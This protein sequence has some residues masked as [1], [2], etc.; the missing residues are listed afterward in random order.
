MTKQTVVTKRNII[1]LCEQDFLFLL[2]QSLNWEKS[3][4]HK[5]GLEMGVTVIQYFNQ[6]QF[7]VRNVLLAEVKPQLIYLNHNGRR[8]GRKVDYKQSPSGF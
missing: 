8:R 2:S 1:V 3:E 5:T 6:F 7:R 4:P